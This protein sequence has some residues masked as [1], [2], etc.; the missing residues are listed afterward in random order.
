M[1]E[2]IEAKRWAPERIE[3][4]ARLLFP[5]FRDLCMFGLGVWLTLSEVVW[6]PD[7]ASP[8]PLALGLITLL[9]GFP[10]G[11]LFD[12]ARKNGGRNGEE[13]TDG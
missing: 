10:A 8:D 13:E 1:A 6:R 3:A 4:T 5:R 12:R 2:E 11:A 7:G 9:L